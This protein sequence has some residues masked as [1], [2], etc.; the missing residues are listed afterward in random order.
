M[1]SSWKTPSSHIIGVIR[2]IAAESGIAALD[3]Q[4]LASSLSVRELQA[5]GEWLVRRRLHPALRQDEK[6]I[7]CKR[8][9]GW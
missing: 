8:F 4:A 1:C 7:A 6:Y 5:I 2:V 3:M 9:E